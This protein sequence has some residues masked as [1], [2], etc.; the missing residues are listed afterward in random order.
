[1]TQQTQIDDFSHIALTYIA[2]FY[3]DQ[4]NYRSLTDLLHCYSTYP[5]F[6][7]D[8]L[9]FVFVDD[10]SPVDVAIPEDLD[11]NILMLKIQKDIP[12]NQPGARNLGVM[13]ARSD[14]IVLTDVD[15]MFPPHTMERMIRHGNPGKNVYKFRLVIEEDGSS[16][17]AHPN[18]LFMSRARFLRHYGYDEDFCGHYGFDD[19]MMWRWQ[20]Y[21]GTRFLYFR[22]KYH[23]M[24]RNIDLDRSYHSLRRELEHNRKVADAKRAAWAKYGPNAGHSRRFLNFKWDI[25]LDGR[26]SRRPEPRKNMLWTKTWQLRQLLPF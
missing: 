15:H 18:T 14:K 23:C 4:K 6:I 19:A 5:D 21:H 16:D 24:R 12:W 9:Q 1:M 7:L 20:R 17:K 22:S 10:G 13:Y 25:V 11:L 3:F 2:T 8:R 26:R